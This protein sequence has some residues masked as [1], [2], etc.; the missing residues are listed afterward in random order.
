MNDK[1]KK[2]TIEDLSGLNPHQDVS[3]FFP[4]NWEG[5]LLDILEFEELPAIDRVWAV[6]QLLPEEDARGFAVEHARKALSRSKKP[7][8]RSVAAVDAAEGYALGKVS[9]KK[10]TAAEHLAWQALMDVERTTGKGTIE[11]DAARAA[12]NAADSQ[13]WLAAW[14][15]A[16]A[17]AS[18][19]ARESK[20]WEESNAAWD[21]Q[22]EYLKLLVS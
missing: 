4:D 17:A 6:A 1:K 13:D 20:I 19:I 8:P 7:D 3:V 14:G 21:A 9:Q 16:W 11:C 10:L 22:I 18:G 2:F 5:T 15:V 12:R